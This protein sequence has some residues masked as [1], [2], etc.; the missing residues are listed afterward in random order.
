MGEDFALRGSSLK[1]CDFNRY[2]QDSSY[3]NDGSHKMVASRIMAIMD[4]FFIVSGLHSAGN[5]I[6]PP[7]AW[8]EPT[9]GNP[10][11]RFAH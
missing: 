2:Q 8:V 11:T 9:S 1:V 10:Q 6:V 3:A 4:P 5:V 7:M